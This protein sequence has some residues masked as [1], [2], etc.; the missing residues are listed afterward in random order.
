M[1]VLLRSVRLNFLF[2]WAT[3][4]Y[5]KSRV[6]LSLLFF[7][8]FCSLFSCSFFHSLSLFLALCCRL[9]PRVLGLI[10]RLNLVTITL[11]NLILVGIIINSL[12]TTKTNPS[13][14]HISID[15]RMQNLSNFLLLYGSI[16][17]SFAQIHSLP[18]YV[19]LDLNGPRETI[20]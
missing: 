14:N 16:H 7:P 3:A 20:I 10:N 13:C 11:L 2:H 4:P 9:L 15:T 8:L 19:R 1:R 6:S 5:E 12:T 17:C 18:Y